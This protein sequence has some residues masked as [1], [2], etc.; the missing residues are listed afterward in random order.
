M[1]SKLD[2]TEQHPRIIHTR[3]DR[4]ITWERTDRRRQHTMNQ[5]MCLRIRPRD[6]IRLIRTKT[7]STHRRPDHLQVSLVSLLEWRTC[8]EDRVRFESGARTSRC[9]TDDSWAS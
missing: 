9:F 6:P 1:R 7:D 5:I 8:R 3:K 4:R 2:I